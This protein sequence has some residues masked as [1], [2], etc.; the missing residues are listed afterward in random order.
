MSEVCALIPA[1]GHGARFGSSENKIFALLLGRPLLAWTIQAF[2]DC[3]AIDSIVLVGSEND[4]PRLRKIG[5]QYGGGKLTAVVQGG[6]DRQSSVRLGLR[7]CPDEAEFVAVHDAARPCV[8]PGL[9]A[10][11]VS[12]ARESDAVTV[13]LPLT[14]TLNR[15]STAED[16]YLYIGE[17]LR[18]EETCAIQTPQVFLTNLLRE[19]HEDAFRS[20]FSVTD[21]AGLVCS[22]NQPVRIVLGSPENLKVT[23]PEDILLA[24]AILMRKGRDTPPPFPLSTEGEGEGVSLPFRIGYGYDVHPFAT[25]RP[26]YLGGVYFPEAE[27][28]LQG[29]SDA[30]ALLHA[31]CDALL[32]AA[33]LGDIG[34][35]FPPSDN[36]HKDRRSTEFLHEVG[37]AI[38]QAGWQVGNMDVMVLAETPRVGPRVEEIKQVIAATLGIQPTQISIKATTNEGL[39]FIGRGE[40]IAV[41]ATALLMASRDTT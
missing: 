21:D 9:I 31:V 38:A 8:T 32:G 16:G 34:T 37:D 35:H 5:E 28:G 1:A 20:N 4:L 13:A 30:D 2:A 27:R 3:G 19:K 40:G 26:M 23:R 18:R 14:D 11:A 17:P 25:G 15:W 36:R 22:P 29:H 33:G 7:A 12:A 6:A 41:H 24:E 39:G 10:A